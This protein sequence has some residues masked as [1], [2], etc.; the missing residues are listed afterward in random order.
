MKVCLGT[1]DGMDSGGLGGAAIA[2]TWRRQGLVAARRPGLTA[3]MRLCALCCCRPTPSPPLRVICP[4]KPMPATAISSPLTESCLPYSCGSCV[5]QSVAF[6]ALLP[7]S[8]LFD[9]SVDVGESMVPV[10]R[11]S[12]PI[13]LT[14]VPVGPTGPLGQSR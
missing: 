11:S 13:N 10:D 2:A 7:G 6:G 14:G 3:A 12:H 5:W 1:T 4:A 8:S 9:F